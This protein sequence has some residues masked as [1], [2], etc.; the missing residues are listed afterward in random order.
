MSQ[1]AQQT[2]QHVVVYTTADLQLMA[3][4]VQLLNI[5]HAKPKVTRDENNPADW[6][7]QGQPANRYQRVE[8]RL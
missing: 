4:P 3:G 2:F 5:F 8:Q 7:R 6:Q 1:Y